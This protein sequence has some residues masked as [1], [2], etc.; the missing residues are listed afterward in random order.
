MR[1][2]TSWPAGDSLALWLIGIWERS[3]A[4]SG[5]SRSAAITEAI[6]SAYSLYD[7]VIA[8]DLGGEEALDNLKER[9]AQ[10]GIRLASDMVPNHTGL[11]SRWTVEHP[12]WFV[13]LDY[14]PYPGLQLYGP[15]PLLR[16]G[17]SASI[18]RTATGTRADAAVVFK[19]FDHRNGRTRYIYHGNDGTSTPWN[20]TAQLNYLMA[21]V[22]EAVIQTILH[23]A[24]QFRI[25]R[26]DAAMTLAKKHYQRLWFPQPGHGSGVPPG[27]SMA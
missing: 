27:P 8:G 16:H 6:S 11:Y 12:D 7:Y 1:N 21:E 3:P 10:R 22:R 25:I 23:V 14:P 2:W 17:R 15:R 20:D 4:S 18:S 5:S 24:R 9:C 19:H 26:F 13:Q